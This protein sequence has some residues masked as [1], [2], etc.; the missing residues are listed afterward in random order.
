MFKRHKNVLFRNKL[1]RLLMKIEVMVNSGVVS[2]EEIHDFINLYIGP[3]VY[4]VNKLNYIHPYEDYLEHKNIEKIMNDYAL[5]LKNEPEIKTK[6]IG[7]IKMLTVYTDGSFNPET[8]EYGWAYAI[9]SDA[10]KEEV[11]SDAMIKSDSGKASGEAAKMRNVAG[12]LSAVMRAVKQ[13]YTDHQGLIAEP[14]EVKIVHD[15]TGV[16]DWVTGAWKAKNEFTQSY[17]AFMEKYMASGRLI[18]TFE[19]VNGH[20]GVAGNEFVDDLAAKACGVR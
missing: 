12:E 8:K 14:F 17:K 6:L 15:Y 5:V 20:T 4:W 10:F 16:A 7:E 11:G 1:I 2:D 13:L 3:A 18:V 9:Y 19:H